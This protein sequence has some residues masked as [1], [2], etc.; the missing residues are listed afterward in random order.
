M[1]VYKLLLPPFVLFG[2]DPCFLSINETTFFHVTAYLIYFVVIIC[3]ISLTCLLES[4]FNLVQL[5]ALSLFYF[6]GVTTHPILF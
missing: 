6:S 2:H 5:M 1:I 3:P 4:Y